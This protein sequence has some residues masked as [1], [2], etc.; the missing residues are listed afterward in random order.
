VKKLFFIFTMFSILCFTNCDEDPYFYNTAINQS[1]EVVT[2]NFYT[3][4]DTDD[5]ALDPGDTKEIKLL[6]GSDRKYGINY[7]SPDKRV[8]VIESR[9]EYIF[10]DRQSYEVKI[11]NFMGKE[12]ILK[13]TDGWMDNID[14]T[15]SNEVQKN[16]NWLIYTI[17]P[18]FKVT[19][20]NNF[21]FTISTYEFNNGVFWVTIN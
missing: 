5:I 6:K 19:F 20:E 10:K 14:F 16:S 17:N 18:K 2:A 4:I 1:N 12:G 15:E 21:S 13:E 8:S 7:Y 11:L 3:G 9:G